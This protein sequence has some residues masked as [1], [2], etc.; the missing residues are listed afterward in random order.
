MPSDHPNPV[1]YE[2]EGDA[3][4]KPETPKPGHA[5]VFTAIAAPLNPAGNLATGR[6]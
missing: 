4:E 2:I 1:V 3:T 6:H 5:R